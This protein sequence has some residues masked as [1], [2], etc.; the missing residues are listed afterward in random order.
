MGRMRGL[1]VSRGYD[2]V[3]TVTDSNGLGIEDWWVDPAFV[4]RDLA[5]A[6]AEAVW[7]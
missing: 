3:C 2:Y 7:R 6:V 5:V 4:D 1:M